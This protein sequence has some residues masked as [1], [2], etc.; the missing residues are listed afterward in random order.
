VDTRNRQDVIMADVDDDETLLLFALP[1]EMREGYTYPK[2]TLKVLGV[3]AQV[4]KQA[5]KEKPLYYVS[6]LVEWMQNLNLT[7]KQVKGN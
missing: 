5:D 7:T 4:S 3:F 6:S 1:P 2:L